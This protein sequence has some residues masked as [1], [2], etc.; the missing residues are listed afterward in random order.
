MFADE[1]H[2]SGMDQNHAIELW[3]RL[4][5]HGT[6]PTEV[7]SAARVLPSYTAGIG[8]WIDRLSDQYLRGSGSRRGLCQ[9]TAHFKLVLAPYGGGKTHFLLT[10]GARA[11]EDGFAVSYVPCGGGVSLESP[12]DVHREHCQALAVTGKRSAWPSPIA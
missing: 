11:L 2:M 9:S 6:A 3:T 4:G 1:D 8:P 7:T 10:L 12:L 5:E